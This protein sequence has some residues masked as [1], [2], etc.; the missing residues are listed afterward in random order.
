MNELVI[1]GKR[2]AANGND[3]TV[4]RQGLAIENSC[5]TDQRSVLDQARLLTLPRRARTAT[6]ASK[7]TPMSA[8]VAGSGTTDV[9]P[10]PKVE[11]LTPPSSIMNVL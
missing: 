1:I 11:R 2:A 10:M 6:S 5:V 3:A 8:N 7:P 9:V 4:T